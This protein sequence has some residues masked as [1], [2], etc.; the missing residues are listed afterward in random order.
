MTEQPSETYFEKVIVP[1]PEPAPPKK[2]IVLLPYIL[3]FVFIL[4]VVPA[5]L[6]FVSLVLPGPLKEEKTVVIPRGKSVSE[7]AQILDQN[8]ILINP[9][10]LRATAHIMAED[11]LKAGEYKFMPGQSVLDV[12]T[13]LR[14]GHVVVHQFTAPEG[15]TSHEIVGLLRGAK[16]LSGDLETVPEE[17]TV[18]PESYQ[19]ILGDTRA[20]VLAHM[21]KDMKDTLEKL[22]AN[23]AEGLPLASPREALILASIVEKETGQKAEERA[24]VAGV[25]INRLKLKMPL[26]TD[27]TVIYALTKGQTPLGRALTNA[28][29]AI[30]SPYNTYLNPGLPP[31][32]ICNP[33]RA[34]IE[35]ALHPEVHDF[36]YFVAD[37]SGGHAFSKSLKDHNKNVDYWRSLKKP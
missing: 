30:A 2:K 24:R 28:D 12:T 21:Q 16:D 34:A 19:Y 11:K 6:F 37:G 8:D 29:L 5:P 33:G 15:L 32:P 10:L 18:L 27:P 25:F 7:I 3:L 23:R 17:G 26:Q 35:A 20:S 36:L 13:M 14:D 22:W 1:S 31:G 9:I 4:T